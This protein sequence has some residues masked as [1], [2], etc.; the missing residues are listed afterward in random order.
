MTSISHS[1]CSSEI[2]S[3]GSFD[4]VPG[5]ETTA[6]GWLE[7]ATPDLNHP[8]FDLQSNDGFDWIGK[9]LESEDGGSWQNI[10]VIESIEQDVVLE[11]GMKYY[12]SF[13]YA[14]QPI[15]TLDFQP[16]IIFDNFGGL[17]FFID[18]SLYYSTSLDTTFYTWEE[19]C[20]SFIASSETSTLRI[21]GFG[22]A[23]MGVDGVCISEDIL[24]ID[25]GEDQILCQGKELELKIDDTIRSNQFIWSTGSTEESISVIDQGYYWL[26]VYDQCQVARDSVYINLIQCDCKLYIPN[27]ISL[28]SDDENSNFGLRSACNVINFQLSVYDRWGNL[29]FTSLNI[30]DYWDGNY[31]GS[32][33][34]QGAYMVNFEAEFESGEILKDTEVITVLR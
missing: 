5:K 7:V 10:F 30:D 8:D 9:P 32:R 2:I 26:E 1:Q 28:S 11:V 23:Y 13:Y 20:F 25:I 3:N 18:D 29:I 19:D 27:I 21:M 17:N 4:S 6:D 15:G 14:T 34:E 16:A 12:L 33:V 22:D 31:K 24:K